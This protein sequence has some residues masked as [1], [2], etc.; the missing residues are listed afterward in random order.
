MDCDKI[1]KRP[2]VREKGPNQS[3]QQFGATK[4]APARGGVSLGEKGAR[5]DVGASAGTN[6][7]EVLEIR[8]LAVRRRGPGCGTTKEAVSTR[9][10]WSRGH[11]AVPFSAETFTETT[12]PVTDILFHLL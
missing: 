5:G 1:I 11:L 3:Q 10:A 12:L 8:M 7:P 6:P 4:W 2:L 9:K